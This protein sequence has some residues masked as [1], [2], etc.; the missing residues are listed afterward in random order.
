MS[1]FKKLSAQTLALALASL[2]LQPI[3]AAASVSV[4]VWSDSRLDSDTGCSNESRNLRTIIGGTDGYTVDQSITNLDDV[5]LESKLNSNSFFFVPDI[6]DP[7]VSTVLPDSAKP[8]IRDWVSDGGVLV[9]TGTYRGKDVEFLNEIFSLGLSNVMA[10]SGD[11]WAKNANVTGTEFAENIGGTAPPASLSWLSATDAVD[12]SSVPAENNFKAMWGTETDATVSTMTYGS[13]T[14]IFMSYDFFSAGP[15][16]SVTGDGW[17]DFILPAA[18]NYAAALSNAGLDNAT[19]SGGDLSYTVSASGTYY[20]MVV[21]RSATAPSAAQLEAQVSYSGVTIE[22]NGSGSISS[23]VEEVISI[24]GLSAAK[25]YSAYLVTKDSSDD[26]FTDVEQVDFSTLPG[27][28]NVTSVSPGDGKLVVTISPNGTETN[29]EYM[30][31]D[32]GTWVARSPAS[33]ATGWEITGLTN[34]TS[35]DIKFRSTFDGLQSVATSNVSATPSAA[36]A[37]DAPTGLSA[38]ATGSSSASLTWTAPSSDGGAAISGYKV[39]YSTDSGSN[40]LVKIASTGTAEGSAS[41]TGLTSGESYLFRVSAIN[42]IGTGSSVQTSASLTIPFPP[43]PYYGPTSRPL[44]RT[45]ASFGEEVTIPGFRMDII[46]SVHAGNIEFEIVSTSHS[47]LVVLVPGGCSGLIDLE[48]V[49][50]ND[51]RTGTYRIPEA[52]NVTAE[53]EPLDIETQADARVNAGSFKGYV[54]VYAKGYEGKRLS[55]KIGDDWVIVPSLN[56]SFERIV[57]FTGAGVDISVRIYI[58]RNLMNTINLTTR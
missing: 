20:W 53:A 18:L 51:E 35:Y 3:P 45:V 31:D 28:P 2:L 17:V 42:S 56:S 43:P 14:I 33:T 34:G 10:S 16:C 26:S 7:S 55:A 40:W 29:F 15:G 13:G 11:S 5:N 46:Q 39:E 50:R 58:D 44:T 30:L 8:V 32:S 22:G 24:T 19:T 36:V 54:A 37:P 21:E 4:A 9:Q 12:G 6:E 48:L 49:W 27:T 25:E 52:L 1:N 57:D 23:G 41:L 47:A 38:S